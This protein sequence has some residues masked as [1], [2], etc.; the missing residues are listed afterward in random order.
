MFNAKLTLA[1]LTLATFSTLAAHHADAATLQVCSTCPYSSIQGAVNVA[2]SGDSI[3]IA[4]GQYFESVQITGARSLI[5]LPSSGRVTINAAGFDRALEILDPGASIVLQEIDLIKADGFA[6]LVNHGRVTL[7][8]VQVV[9]NQ[10]SFGG[11]YNDGSLLTFVNT[12][13]AGNVATA[14]GSAGGLNNFAWVDIWN[15]TILGNRGHE[16]GGF[17]SSGNSRVTVFASSISGNHASSMGGGYFTS[18]LQA[19]VDIKSSS[20]FSANSAANCNTYYDV[21]KTPQCVN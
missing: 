2:A 19:V 17:K 8:S 6:G 16:G 18:S 9:A 3:V 10:G 11:I 21:R 12:V 4:P 14:L 5:L 1:A 20:S 15:T 13:I 7:V